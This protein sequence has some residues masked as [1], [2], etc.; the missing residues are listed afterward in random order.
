[1][2]YRRRYARRRTSFRPRRSYV[3]RSYGARRRTTYG[4]RRY[5][6]RISNRS[7][8]FNRRYNYKEVFYGNV[9]FSMAA[10]PT[11]VAAAGTITAQAIPSFSTRSISFD[12]YKIY[13]A[14]VLIEAPKFQAASLTEAGEGSDDYNGI[15]NVRHY[16]AVDHTDAVV[17]SLAQID[18]FVNSPAAKSAPWNKPLKVIFTPMY[19]TRTYEGA[20]TDG[21]KPATGWID[22]DDSAVPHY[23]WK[24]IVDNHSLLPD[25]HVDGIVYRVKY[26]V[27]YG[28][29]NINKPGNT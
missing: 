17:P 15:S 11:T 20:T 5:S 23:G 6:R 12:Q 22:V 24:W 2:V 9:D 10:S 13:K 18:T 27:Y 29:K 21:F 14:K 16:L 25:L 7:R 28:L 8:W 3:R 19:L 4:R 26:T 1:M